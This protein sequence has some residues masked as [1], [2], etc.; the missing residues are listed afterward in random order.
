MYGG[1]LDDA[2]E[3]GAMDKQWEMVDAWMTGL[4]TYL[5]PP[6]TRFQILPLLSCISLS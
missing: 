2:S 3:M 5:S 6:M 1:G 4:G